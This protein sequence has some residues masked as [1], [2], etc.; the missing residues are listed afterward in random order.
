MLQIKR[1]LD[2]QGNRKGVIEY[3]R[4]QLAK[5]QFPDAF[6]PPYDPMLKMGALNID[7]SR[8]MDSKKVSTLV[9]NHRLR[10][11]N[12]IFLINLATKALGKIT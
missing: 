10:S 8:V 5:Y 6:R 3:A 12:L 7:K 9:L 2:G 1:Y 11:N 4:E